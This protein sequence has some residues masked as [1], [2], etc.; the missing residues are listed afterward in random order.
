MRT[1]CTCAHSMSTLAA[2]PSVQ[3]SVEG[4]GRGGRSG[5]ERRFKRSQGVRRGEGWRARYRIRETH[6]S[7]DTAIS[8]ISCLSFSPPP[9]VGPSDCF[10]SLS[11]PLPSAPPPQ[12]SDTVSLPLPLHP[13][14]VA[15]RPSSTLLLR[16]RVST[17]RQHAFR[18]SV[19]W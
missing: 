6:A 7:A 19:Q 14:Q 8:N 1:A 16:Q 17:Q 12:L 3:I 9:C 2:S 5:R 13:F 18:S 10:A 11:P 4:D 15:I